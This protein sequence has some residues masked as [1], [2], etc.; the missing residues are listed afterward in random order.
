MV[1][2]MNIT[3]YISPALPALL[4]IVSFS[5]DIYGASNSTILTQIKALQRKSVRIV[6]KTKFIANDDKIFRVHIS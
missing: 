4:A 2:D 3:Q 6:A 5:A 1:T